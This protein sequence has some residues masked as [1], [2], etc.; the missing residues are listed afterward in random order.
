MT[1]WFVMSGFDSLSAPVNSEKKKPSVDFFTFIQMLLR[2]LPDNPEVIGHT[3]ALCGKLIAEG[4]SEEQALELART[5]GR[6]LVK[7]KGLNM[8]PVTFNFYDINEKKPKDSQT[9]LTYNSMTGGMIT[10]AMWEDGNFWIEDEDDDPITGVTHW[11]ALREPFQ[12]AFG[13]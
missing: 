9:V 7:A 2:N 10:V 1:L 8:T 11:A 5:V 6:L 13:Q 12:N 3:K 4:V